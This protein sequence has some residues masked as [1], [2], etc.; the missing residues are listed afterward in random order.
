[1]GVKSESAFWQAVEKS[2]AACARW[3]RRDA[4]QSLPAL[5]TVLPH[6]GIPHPEGGLLDAGS[7]HMRCT[8]CGVGVEGVEA[9]GLV[10]ERPEGPMLVVI[11]GCGCGRLNANGFTEEGGDLVR[12]LIQANPPGLDLSRRAAVRAVKGVLW[13]R[14]LRPG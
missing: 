11:W 10:R 4:W 7:L 13:L 1:M 12:H 5:E 9:R 6:P 2:S 14:Y 3:R 8:R